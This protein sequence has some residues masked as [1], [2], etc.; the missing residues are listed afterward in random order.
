MRKAGIG[1]VSMKTAGQIRDKAPAL[2]TLYGKRF[3][4]QQLSACQRAYAYLLGSGK[5]DAFNS[6]MPN[7]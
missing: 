4:G 1:I 5:I 7:L 6:H 3:A 2:E